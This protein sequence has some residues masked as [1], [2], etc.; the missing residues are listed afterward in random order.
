MGVSDFSS[1]RGDNAIRSQAA[2]AQ[3]TLFSGASAGWD[4][5]PRGERNVGGSSSP[6]RGSYTLNFSLL[7]IICT[8]TSKQ[9]G[10]M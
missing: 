5:Y 9:R 4:L 3:R 8:R 10:L 6:S 2:Y 1:Q 7:A